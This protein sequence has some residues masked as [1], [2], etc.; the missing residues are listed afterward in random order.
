MQV[1][2]VLEVSDVGKIRAF[3]NIHAADGFRNEPVE[4]GIA[5]AMNV[6]RKVDRHVVHESGEVGA[7]IEVP[8]RR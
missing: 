5:L 4:V 7:V 2:G 8:P 6:R 3:A 1:A